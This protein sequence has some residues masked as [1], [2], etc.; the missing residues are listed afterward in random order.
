MVVARKWDDLRG[1]GFGCGQWTERGIG[2]GK[3]WW[4]FLCVGKFEN[5]REEQMGGFSPRVFYVLL[6]LIC[7]IYIGLIGDLLEGELN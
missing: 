6:L 1:L 5:K 3:L 7:L 4:I 2:L